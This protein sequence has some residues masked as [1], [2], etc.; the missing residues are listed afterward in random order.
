MEYN[1]CRTPEELL[2]L[3][4][5][6]LEAGGTLPLVIS[7]SS[8]APFLVH[9]RDT[10]YLSKIRKPVKTGDMILYRR[11]QGQLLLHRVCSVDAPGFS[12]V[13]DA[14]TVAESGVKEEQLL[15]VVTAVNR[16][17]KLLT[18]RN[19]LWMFFEKI[20]PRV[21]PLRGKILALYD[22]ISGKRR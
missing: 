8:M 16:K 19:L 22:W 21:I 10:V 2:E 1:K 6:V 7:G 12:L 14:Q 15:A 3:L 11:E 13:G 9:G 20:W 18:K 5:E 17:G 4:P